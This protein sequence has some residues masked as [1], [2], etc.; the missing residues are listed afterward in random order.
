MCFGCTK[1]TLRTPPIVNLSQITN[2]KMLCKIKAHSRLAD[3]A[4][5]YSNIPYLVANESV[6]KADS[7]SAAYYALALAFLL[8]V[9]RV[10]DNQSNPSLIIAALTVLMRRVLSFMC[11]P[12]RRIGVFSADYAPYNTAVPLTFEASIHVRTWNRYSQIKTV[13]R[14]DAAAERP[15]M[16]CFACLDLAIPVPCPGCSV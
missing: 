16:A 15:G 10:V 8:T 14:K 13:C 4:F 12:T 9:F 1:P 7:E 11:I 6:E 3:N 5:H 2:T